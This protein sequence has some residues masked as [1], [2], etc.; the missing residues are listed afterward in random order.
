VTGPRL[1]WKRGGHC[2]AN[3]RKVERRVGTYTM[4]RKEG[5]KKKR[6]Q[7]Y[8]K[9]NKSFGESKMVES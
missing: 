9:I 8:K 5:G 3:G 7:K 2:R 4:K 6:E 1:S